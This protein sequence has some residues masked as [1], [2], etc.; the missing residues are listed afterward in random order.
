MSTAIKNLD[1]LVNIATGIVNR[2]EAKILPSISEEEVK[3][4][5]KMKSQV[6]LV[7]TDLMTLYSQETQN[8]RQISHLQSVL[9]TMDDATITLSQ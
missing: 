8:A 4:L 9:L 1:E 7:L 5:Y 2:L 6:E 3:A